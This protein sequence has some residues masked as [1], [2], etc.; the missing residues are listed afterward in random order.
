MATISLARRRLS[1]ADDSGQGS[2]RPAQTV[3]GSARRGRR[4]VSAVSN[5]AGGRPGVAEH[6]LDDGRTRRAMTGGAA[7]TVAAA[8]H[9]QRI[10]DGNQSAG[11]Y[12]R[13]LRVLCGRGLSGRLLMRLGR[14]DDRVMH[15]C[16]VTMASMRM[17]NRRHARGQKCHKAEQPQN[18]SNALHKVAGAKTVRAY[19]ADDLGRFAAQGNTSSVGS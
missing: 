16:V 10:A 2:G 14:A 19:S 18:C 17:G 3:G 12:R 8:W 11:A 7:S 13:R 15:M 1:A 5:A 6:W 9:R 4:H